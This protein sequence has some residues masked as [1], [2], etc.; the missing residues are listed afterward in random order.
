MHRSGVHPTIDFYRRENEPARL[1]SA[2]APSPSGFIS[3]SLFGKVE[4]GADGF[5]GK[6]HA[7]EVEAY[8]KR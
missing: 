6:W 7:R 1:V 4:D 8:A 2:S 3:A 5:M